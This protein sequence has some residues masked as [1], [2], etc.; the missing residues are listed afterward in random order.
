MNFALVGPSTVISV[1]IVTFLPPE[2]TS[3]TELILNLICC[4]SRIDFDLVS[5]CITSVLPVIAKVNPRIHDY[6]RLTP[7]QQRSSSSLLHQK[8][9]Q[10]FSSLG[11]IITRKP[12][13]CLHTSPWSSTHWSRLRIAS[14]LAIRTIRTQPSL[15]ARFSRNPTLRELRRLYEPS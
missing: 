3:N 4:F 7:T 12:G 8:R 10:N 2:P 11:L 1:L 15:E 14:T 5:P 9:R 6:E 13:H